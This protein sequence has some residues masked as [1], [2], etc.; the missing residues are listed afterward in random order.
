MEKRPKN[1]QELCC[2]LGKREKVQKSKR[3]QGQKYKSTKE[4]RN[5]G[6]RDKG[7]K[8]KKAQKDKMTKGKKA[9]GKKAKK[10]LSVVLHLRDVYILVLFFKPLVQDHPT[11]PSISLPLHIF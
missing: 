2:I 10:Q 11:L 1:N 4:K 8:G 5:K 6:Q 3:V 7:T 9:N